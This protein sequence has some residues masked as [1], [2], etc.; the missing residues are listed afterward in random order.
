MT[1]SLK[2]IVDLLIVNARIATMDASFFIYESA[3]L[4]IVQD[5]IVWIGDEKSAP[6]ARL[7]LDAK[8]NLLTPG[9]IDC[10]THLVYAGHRADDFAKRLQGQSYAKI[11]ASGGGILATVKATQKA[12]FEELYQL[13]SK[14]AQTM[15]SYGTTS[16]EIKS[17]YGLDLPNEKKILQVIQRLQETLPLTIKSTFLG[18][19][20]LNPRLQLSKEAYV[21]E[22]IHQWLPELVQ[23]KLCDA[24][25]AFCEKIAFS[26][27]EVERFFKAAQSYGL[28]IKCHA[29]QL[30]YQKGA[31]TAIKYQAKSVDHLEYL[32][33]KDC[34]ALANANTVAVLL[35]GASYFLKQK[36]LPPIST[37][38]AQQ[39]PMAIASDSNP[40]TSP[41]L[42]LVW[43]MN[44]ACILYQLTIEEAWMGVTRHAAR[45][46]GLE[47]SIGSIELGKQADLVLWSEKELADVILKPDINACQ[48]VI[49]SGRLI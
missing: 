44:M 3:C 1:R 41:F 29:E 35:P 39:V 17:G 45:A 26:P 27:A 31:L 11:A 15:L 12:S 23:D 38:R 6:K 13:A 14:R 28:D 47:E 19:H 22:V 49:K 46:L 2:K 24:V 48:Q 18:L 36:R 37:L 10:H 40:G 4:G 25:D 16:L 8:G 7:C 42:S 20:A 30:S 33:P 43:M 21:D 32:S 9:L 5:K 34:E